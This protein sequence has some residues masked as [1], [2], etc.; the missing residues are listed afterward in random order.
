MVLAMMSPEQVRET[1]R[2]YVDAFERKDRDA[3]VGLFAEDAH[4]VDPVPSPPNVGRPAIADFFDRT[5]TLADKITIDVHHVHVCG[6]E[7]VMVFT[8]T[9]TS[10]GGSFS[11]DVVDLFRF[12]DTGH[13]A[14]LRAYWDPSQVRPAEG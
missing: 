8:G 3:W 6:D 1:I 7:A 10:A 4:Q 5:S 13:I 14:E 2:A 9:A 12:D 11:F